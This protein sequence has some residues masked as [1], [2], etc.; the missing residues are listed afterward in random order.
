MAEYFSHDYHARND[1]KIVTMRTELGLISLGAYWCIIEILYEQNGRIK[2]TDLSTISKVIGCDISLLEKI[3]FDY[4]LFV[5]NGG[6]IEN[7][8]INKRLKVRQEKSEKAS[9]SA[10]SR[11]SK[12]TKEQENS[13]KECERNATSSA[14]IITVQ[15]SDYA[16]KKRKEK[17]KKNTNTAS[18]LFS[19]EDRL[20]FDEV[21]VSNAAKSLSIDKS[22]IEVLIKKFNTHLLTIKKEH[23]NLSEYASH[24]LNWCRISKNDNNQN[25]SGHITSSTPVN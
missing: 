13:E 10:K 4:G 18:E 2:I 23:T 15:T 14:S 12:Y 20:L 3:V 5:K 7:N 21:W 6:H 9:V 25:K 11:W 19:I 16:K 24:F 1:L 17:N 8:S 22:R